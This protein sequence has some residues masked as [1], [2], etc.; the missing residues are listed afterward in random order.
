MLTRE[1]LRRLATPLA[2]AAEQLAGRP[3]A[4]G[5]RYEAVRSVMGAWP[6][7]TGL[8]PR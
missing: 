5:P 2:I 4:I 3:P 1:A 8:T 7:L 6:A